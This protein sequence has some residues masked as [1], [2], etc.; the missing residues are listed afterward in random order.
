MASKI[1]INT[2]NAQPFEVSFFW[3]GRGPILDPPFI[4]QELTININPIQ[5]EG[6]QKGPPPTS[7]SPVTS[8]NVGIGP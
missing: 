1:C 5:D 6:G 3:G 8:T 4:F 2:N 7:F